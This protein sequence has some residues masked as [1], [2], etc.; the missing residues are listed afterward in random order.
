M[1]IA[2]A[3][4]FFPFKTY[5]GASIDYLVKSQNVTLPI[6]SLWGI[7]NQITLKPPVTKGCKK[8]KHRGQQKEKWWSYSKTQI[9]LS[10]LNHKSKSSKAGVR[11]V[12]GC[13]GTLQASVSSAVSL[14]H[15]APQRSLEGPTQTTS[16][17]QKQPSRSNFKHK[18]A[19]SHVKKKKRKA[20]NFWTWRKS[21]NRNSAWR[22]VCTSLLSASEVRE[23]SSHSDRTFEERVE[24]EETLLL[25]DGVKHPSELAC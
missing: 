3:R 13:F 19:N 15:L 2:T 12:S 10:N 8:F 21:R 18:N 22:D 16:N 9:A 5:L 6:N 1:K 23:K 20:V 14:T 25:P 7:L 11:N 4:T 17:K 24:E